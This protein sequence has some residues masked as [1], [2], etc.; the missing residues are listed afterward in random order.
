[1]PS[2]GRANLGIRIVKLLID[3]ISP[4]LIEGVRE[5]EGTY[6]IAHR[7][8][9][10]SWKQDQKHMLRDMII[11]KKHLILTDASFNFL[12]KAFSWADTNLIIFKR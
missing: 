6:H 12:V 3:H 1:M 10:I 8:L 9:W 11:T 4:M 5:L 2:Q 7:M